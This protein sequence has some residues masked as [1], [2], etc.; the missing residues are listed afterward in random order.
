MTA[1]IN[2]LI[3]FTNQPMLI[4]PTFTTAKD[5]DFSLPRRKNKT[6]IKIKSSERTGPSDCDIYLLLFFFLCLWYY[7]LLGPSIHIPEITAKIT[8][9]THSFNLFIIWRQGKRIKAMVWHHN[10][11]KKKF[12]TKCLSLRGPIL[13]LWYMK[14]WL[15]IYKRAKMLPCWDYSWIIL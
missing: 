1:M 7:R 12:Y 10:L 2:G 13:I 11:K 14:D 3:H 4:F 9:T 15:Q 6:I 5:N 8:T